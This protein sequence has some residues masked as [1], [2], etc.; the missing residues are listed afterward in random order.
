MRFE[1]SDVSDWLFLDL[2]TTGLAGGTGTY[3]F[4]VGLGRMTPEGFRLRQHFLGDLAAE[5]ELLASL[6]AELEAAPLL[7]TYN[8]K[9]FDAPLLETRYRLAR[10]RWPLEERPHLDLLY[11]ARRLW[12]LRCGSAR[13]LDLEQMILGHARGEDVPGSLIPH[14]YFDY[15]RGGDARPLE[16]VFRHNA[17]DLL[18]LAALAARL[19]TLAA[20][21]ETT[22][23]DSLE[24]LG[25]ARLF[26]RAQEPERAGALY[27]LALQDHLPAELHTLAQLRLSF[28]YKRRGEHQRATALWRELAEA[29][30]APRTR[31][32]ALEQLAIC[33]EHRLGDPVAATRATQQALE[34]GGEWG[35]RFTHRLQRL[36]RRHAGLYADGNVCATQA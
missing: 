31:L 35:K 19:L 27:E 6:A 24:L 13:L 22:H 29:S 7:V 4:L 11:P 32:M 14:L 30:T 10:M 5:R 16:V 15:L 9:L 23:D 28:L 8:G 33:Y 21:P 26:E 18:T 3:A 17:E 2:E 12:K 1:I 34:L 25:L 20:A 36:A